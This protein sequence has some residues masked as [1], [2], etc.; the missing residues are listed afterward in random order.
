MLALPEMNPARIPAMVV[1]TV[2]KVCILVDTPHRT[3]PQ[4]VKA[5]TTNTTAKV[6]TIINHIRFITPCEGSSEEATSR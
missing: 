4:S 3:A 5:L 2:S 1:T 6:P